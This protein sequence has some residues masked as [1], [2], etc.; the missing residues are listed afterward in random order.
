M[1][2]CNAVQKARNRQNI[3]VF[4]IA[5]IVLQYELFPTYKT[6]SEEEDVS[7]NLTQDFNPNIARKHT[8]MFSTVWRKGGK[9]NVSNIGACLE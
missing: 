9:R 7:K 4:L 1:E 6:A 8:K 3:F 5:L 2:G